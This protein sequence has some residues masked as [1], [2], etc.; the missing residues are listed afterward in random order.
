MAVDPPTGS[1][2]TVPRISLTTTLFYRINTPGVIEKVKNLFKGYNKLILGFN[3]FLPEGEGYK[4]ELTPE[5]EGY[6]RSHNPANIAAAQAAAAAAAAAQGGVP[7]PVTVLGADTIALPPKGGLTNPLTLIPGSQALPGFVPV[8]QQHIAPA[9]PTGTVPGISGAAVAAQPAV[10]TASAS[11]PA[12][13]AGGAAGAG[14]PGQMQQAHAIHYVTKI[15]NRF[16]QEPETYRQFLRILHTYQKEQKGIKEVLEQ[17]SNLFADHSDLLMEFTYF[18]PDAV[19]EQA[20]ERLE[21]AAR[22]SE[23]R[24][25]KLQAKVQKKANAAAQAQ[26]QAAQVQAQQAAAAAANGGANTAA[27]GASLQ[28]QAA[29]HAKMFGYPLGAAPAPGGSQVSAIPVGMTPSVQDLMMNGMNAAQAQAMASAMATAANNGQPMTLQQMQQMHQALGIAPGGGPGGDVGSSLA[30][31]KRARNSAGGA[32]AGAASAGVG[33]IGGPLGGALSGLSSGTSGGITSEAISLA[34]TSVS[35]GHSVAMTAQLLASQYPSITP[36]YALTLAQAAASGLAGIGGVGGMGN[37][38]GSGSLTPEEIAYHQ[39]LTNATAGPASKKA[40]TAPGVFGGPTGAFNPAAAAA[41]AAAVG[42]TP[43]QAGA[44]GSAKKQNRRK[45]AAGGAAGPGGANSAAVNATNAA[46]SAAAA[47]AGLNPLD[48][49]VAAFL[50]NASVAAAAAVASATATES[51]VSGS[52]TVS[53][54]KQAAAGLTPVVRESNSSSSSGLQNQP[55]TRPRESHLGMSAERKFFDQMKDVLLSISRD[56]WSDFVKCLDMFTNDALPK[57]E[58]LE[59]VSELLGPNNISLYHEFKRL[60]DNR[61]DYQERKED[62]W[63]SVPLSEI[64][65][66]QCRKCTPSYRALPRDYP[67]PKCSE[68]NEEEEKVLNDVVS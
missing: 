48:P 12:V 34:A 21:R 36:A 58:M 5:E 50:A 60:L 25:A 44:V 24:K 26:A 56:S 59:V 61:H 16:S 13:G 62:L 42:V 64:D 51:G 30:G 67:K 17:V 40:N 4:I 23:A 37:G 8:S 55:P 18:L 47:A 49:A 9:P 46:L 57:D 35:K 6:D 41:A 68:R 65:Y 2:L 54:L 20:K 22:E 10:V 7:T 63:F 39:A 52:T 15:R 28:S 53:S 33:G 31:N 27:S 1:I 19:Q 11:A 32:V 29:M 38:N 3:T 43:G 45:N 14:P 66:S